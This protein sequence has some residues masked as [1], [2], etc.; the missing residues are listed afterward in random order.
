[1]S[2]YSDPVKWSEQIAKTK[3]RIF[4]TV[5]INCSLLYLLLWLL[6][7]LTMA[8]VGFG[9]SEMPL[10]QFMLYAIGIFIIGGI[11]PGHNLYAMYRMIKMIKDNE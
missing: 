6:Y 7:E 10:K 5:A 2:L 3:T 11:L 1:M 9:F 8:T 4:I